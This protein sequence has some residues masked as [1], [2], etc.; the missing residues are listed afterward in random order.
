[1]NK[2]VVSIFVILVFTFSLFLPVNAVKIKENCKENLSEDDVRNVQPCPTA[3][4]PP[5]IGNFHFTP[6]G[7]GNVLFGEW[8]QI[9]KGESVTYKSELY[10][11]QMGGGAT[12][13]KVD[14]E[15][16]KIPSTASRMVVTLR[17]RKDG[18]S[19]SEICKDT[20]YKNQANSNGIYNHKLKRTYNDDGVYEVETRATV[21]GDTLLHGEISWGSGGGSWFTLTTG[22]GNVKSK[23]KTCNI[24][25]LFDLI[26]RGNIGIIQ[27]LLR[28]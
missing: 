10:F 12:L 28:S 21:Y 5:G 14:G 8:K 4:I 25:D 27:G 9:A 19:W 18:G 6:K 22:V 24:A 11:H 3:A 13:I 23:I 20:I 1:M 15:W 26:L 2:M 17:E 7:N 16:V